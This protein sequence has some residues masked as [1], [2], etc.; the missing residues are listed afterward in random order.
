[1]ARNIATKILTDA[2][3]EMFRIARMTASSAT[4][5]NIAMRSITHAHPPA[6][7]VPMME[8]FAMGLNLAMK[9]ITDALIP[10]IRALMM[11]YGATERKCATKKT[12]HASM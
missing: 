6:I 5:R 7:P 2:I 4:A 8:F 12:G 11:V 3:T 1:M 9:C 10:E